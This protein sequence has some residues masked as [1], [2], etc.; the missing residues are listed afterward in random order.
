[1]AENKRFKDQVMSSVQLYLEGEDLKGSYKKVALPIDEW[2]FYLR[3][4]LA[5]KALGYWSEVTELVED[6]W[7]AKGRLLTSMGYTPKRASLTFFGTTSSD[8]SV[9]GC[10]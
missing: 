8:N 5:G 4:N 1:M 2:I 3:G 7:V 10:R 9:I 6:Y